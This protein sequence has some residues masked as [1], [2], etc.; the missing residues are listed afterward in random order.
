MKTKSSS[1][2]KASSFSDDDSD[3]TWLPIAFPKNIYQNGKLDMKTKSS[4]TKASSISAEKEEMAIMDVATILREIHINMII[5]E[6]RFIF[7]YSYCLTPTL[8][9]SSNRYLNKSIMKGLSLVSFE[10]INQ[11][12]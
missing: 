12:S 9:N 10:R 7:L 1:T 4:T 11:K 6:F 2:T 8:L 3:D 5:S